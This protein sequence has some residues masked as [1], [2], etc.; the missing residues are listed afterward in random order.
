MYYIFLDKKNQDHRHIKF[1]IYYS[2]IFKNPGLSLFI[3][4]SQNFSLLHIIL[5]S[6][7]EVLHNLI[8]S[9][10]SKS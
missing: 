2:I 6:V 4:F 3:L 10:R 9:G 7:L 1:H 8:I 5:L